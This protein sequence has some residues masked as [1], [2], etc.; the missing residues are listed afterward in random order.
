MLSKSN[1]DCYR[2]WKNQYAPKNPHSPFGDFPKEYLPKQKIEET[3][4]EPVQE[5]TLSGSLTKH[6]R[7][8]GNGGKTSSTLEKKQNYEKPVPKSGAFQKR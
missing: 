2:P 3:R 5:L 4:H 6:Q 1:N 8:R 7:V